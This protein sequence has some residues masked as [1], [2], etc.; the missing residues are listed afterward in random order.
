MMMRRTVEKLRT[1]PQDL[2]KLKALRGRQGRNLN[3]AKALTLQP[4]MSPAEAFKA[5]GEALLRQIEAE[6]V[7]VR[8]LSP[9]GVHRM[10]IELRRLRA[11]ISVFAKLLHD[12]KSAHAKKELK[13]LASRLAPA[14]DLHVMQVKVNRHRIAR[15]SPRF[16]DRLAASRAAAFERAKAAVE[17]RRFQILLRD[18]QQWVGAGRLEVD[19]A[20]GTEVRSARQFAQDILTARAAKVAKRADELPSLNVEQ[21]H[22]LRIAAKKLYYAAGLFETLFVER[23]TARRLASFR[24]R[25]K[26]LLDALGALND[27]AVRQRLVKQL[28]RAPHRATASEKAAAQALHAFDQ[29]ETEALLK[30][31]AKAGRRLAEQRLFGD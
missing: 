14:R 20:P 31:A 30:T 25:L 17:Q 19:P 11:T 27:I 13:W 9:D 21:R 22:R 16:L 5:I 7:R 12:D 18:I 3:P 28:L 2:H 23:K 24:K 6:Q 29:G 26:K 1:P 8:K 15:A 10:R 4:G